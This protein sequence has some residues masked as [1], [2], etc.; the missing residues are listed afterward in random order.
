MT[1][2]PRESRYPTARQPARLREGAH[3]RQLRPGQD[4]WVMEPP[5][6]DNDEHD[7]QEAGT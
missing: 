5:Q 7:G 6:A 3:V 4:V 2:H 1:G